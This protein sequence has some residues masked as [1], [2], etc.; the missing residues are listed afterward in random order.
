MQTVHVPAQI[1]QKLLQTVSDRGGPFV[2]ALH[3][4]GQFLQG[5]CVLLDGG[6]GGLQL[7]Q[8]RL[9]GLGGG[10]HLPQNIHG[11]GQSLLSGGQVPHHGFHGGGKGAGGG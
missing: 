4:S 6:D 3:V 11:L 1:I 2:V 8:L 7:L 5:L 9:Q 10:V